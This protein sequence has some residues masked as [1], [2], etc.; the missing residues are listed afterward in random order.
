MEIKGRNGTEPGSP[1]GI[2]ASD[3]ECVETEVKVAAEQWMLD[4]HGMIVGEEED[5]VK[6][7]VNRGVRGQGGTV[8]VVDHADLGNRRRGRGALSGNRKFTCFLRRD[9]ICSIR[10]VIMEDEVFGKKIG[11]VCGVGEHGCNERCE[12]DASCSRTEYVCDR[13]HLDEAGTNL[14]LEQPRRPRRFLE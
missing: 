14:L 5:H 11:E 8:L 12:N 9:R 2:P 13:E 1:W 3:E 10:I 4:G 7:F 6:L